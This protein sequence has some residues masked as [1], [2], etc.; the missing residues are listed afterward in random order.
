MAV[1]GVLLRTF[2]M[3]AAGTLVAGLA[4]GCGSDGG[5]AAPAATDTAGPSESTSPTAEPSPSDS[6]SPSQTQTPAPASWPACGE[7]WVAD[8][9]LPSP[10]KGCARDGV[11]VPADAI[12][13]SMGAVLVTYD[14]R[15]W[16]VPGHVVSQ[17]DGPLQDDPRYR[18]ARAVC[19][20]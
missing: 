19:T 16:G 2:A 11:A 6:A 7:A 18:Q 10:Y 9:N 4:A 13:C 3:I 12:H 15:F 5:D 17:S 14:D 1:M 20:A 8:A